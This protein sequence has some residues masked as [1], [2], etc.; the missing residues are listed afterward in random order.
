MNDAGYYS[1]VAHNANHSK[2]ISGGLYFDKAN[3][4]KATAIL[5]HI[6]NHLK[7]KD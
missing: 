3:T 2:L 1:F 6:V 7:F 4:D 5:D